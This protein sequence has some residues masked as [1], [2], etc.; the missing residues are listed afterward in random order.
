MPMFDPLYEDIVNMVYLRKKTLL[1]LN[2]FGSLVVNLIS[3][4]I[5]EK[6]DLGW[7]MLQ[8]TV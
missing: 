3:N 5:T 8:A 1:E 7:A 4:K 2:E 6:A